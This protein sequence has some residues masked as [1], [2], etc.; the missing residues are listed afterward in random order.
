[1]MPQDPS[2]D[3]ED[4]YNDEAFHDCCNKDDNN[5]GCSE[6]ECTMPT[7]SS[8]LHAK[9]LICKEP[10]PVHLADAAY[11]VCALKRLVLCVCIITT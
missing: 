5:S 9:N 2:F 7:A 10:I 11:D 8:L 4:D 3:N 6:D 1:M